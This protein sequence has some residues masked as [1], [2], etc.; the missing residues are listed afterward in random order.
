MFLTL[1]LRAVPLVFSLSPNLSLPPTVAPRLTRAPVPPI[2]PSLLLQSPAPPTL[3]AGAVFS[4][5]VSCAVQVLRQL[6]QATQSPL[7]YNLLLLSSVP[8][9]QYKLPEGG[10]LF[11][12][13]SI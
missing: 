8:S 4:G 10:K 13:L 11:F 6:H 12:K 7:T 5:T 1:A 3:K 9:L 2:L